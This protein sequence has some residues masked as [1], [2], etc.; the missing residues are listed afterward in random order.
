MD[1]PARFC[2][3][4]AINA[5]RCGRAIE[6]AGREVARDDHA[7]FTGANPKKPGYTLELPTFKPGARY[8]VRAQVAGDG[9]TDSYGV[10]YWQPSA[11][12]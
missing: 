5:S 3:T 1:A 9:G 12:K 7:G 4:F 10:V 2:N 11:A 8:T 6:A